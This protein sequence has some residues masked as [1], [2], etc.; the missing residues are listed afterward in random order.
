LTGMS[1]SVILFSGAEHYGEIFRV[2]LWPRP[3]IVGD[4]LRGL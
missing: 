3:W 2:I 1:R 4:L